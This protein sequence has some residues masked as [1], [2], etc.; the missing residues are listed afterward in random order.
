MPL[1][2]NRNLLGKMFV[3][4]NINI[5]P[6]HKNSVVA[7]GNFDG[8]HLGHQKV[9]LEAKKLAKKK[10]SKFG[11]ITF[12]PI[13]MVFFKKIKNHRVQ[14]LKQKIHSLEKLKLDF[15]IIIKFNKTFS[16][17]SAENFIIKI[18]VKKI[19]A[20]NIFV[21]KNFRF[22]KNRLGDIKTLKKFEKKFNYKTFITSPLSKNSKMISST[23]IRKKISNGN[24]NDAAK[25]LGKHWSIEGEVVKG[26]QRGRKIG[27]PT[28]NIKL[29]SY[30][31]PKFG[32]YKVLVENNHLKLKKNGIANIGIRP[33]FK[34]KEPLLEVNIFGI[35]KNLYKKT[36][37]VNLLKFIR[38]EKKFKNLENL[39]NQIKKDI[40]KVK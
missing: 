16:N 33:T 14:S 8:V 29:G 3:Y 21:S 4:K 27:F 24:I 35:K 17:I 9:L 26:Y 15:L 18:L 10:K 7:I 31:L 36:L 1:I 6:I 28:C 19:N 12:E 5:K 2:I 20:E 38:K 30:V 32:V 34:G 25:L 40:Q 22:G 37:K 39:K 11:L 13:P 23:L